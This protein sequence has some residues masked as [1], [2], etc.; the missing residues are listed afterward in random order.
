MIIY[1]THRYK[2]LNCRSHELLE[3]AIGDYIGDPIRA[4]VLTAAMKRDKSNDFDGKPYIEGFDKFSISH[5]GDTWAVLIDKREC[6]L[7]I[8]YERGCDYVA[9]ARRFFHEE[10]AAIVGGKY[11]NG[12]KAEA[13]AMS[14]FFRIWTKREAFIK[15]IGSS[16]VY[17]GFPPMAIHQSAE[18]ENKRY[19]IGNVEMPEA[20]GL[21]AAICLDA[22]RDIDEKLIYKE[23]YVKGQ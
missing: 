22:S 19:Y 3:V 9:I 20:P 13:E 1:Y 15:A 18:Y 5:S 17:E 7:D 21:H 6:G 2:K 10:D 14:E 12:G 16:V 8:Q 11:S 23:M 4:S